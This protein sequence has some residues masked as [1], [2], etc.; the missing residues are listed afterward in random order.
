MVHELAP[1]S[2]RLGL[3]ARSDEPDALHDAVVDGVEMVAIMSGIGMRAAARATRRLLDDGVAHVVVVGIAGGIAPHLDIGALVVPEVVIHGDTGRHHRPARLGGVEPAGAIRSSDEFLTDDA[4][5]ARLV[6]EG[7]VALDMETAAVA[8]ACEARG[9]P[10]SVFRAISDRPADRLVDTAVW[11]MTTS[12][13][14]ADPDALARY[15]DSHPEAASR[16]ARMASD[17]ELAV[18]VAAEAAI[19]ACGVSPRS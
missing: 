16:L 17:M 8:Q 1:L 6:A 2:D 7:V 5:L 13:G 3:V 12:D 10:W 18:S 15:L 4:A 11:E 9:V 19:R 14:R